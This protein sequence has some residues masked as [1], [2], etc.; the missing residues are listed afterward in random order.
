M[1]C[2]INLL[3]RPEQKIAL[4]DS[5]AMPVDFILKGIAV[6]KHLFYNICIYIIKFI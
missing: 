1:L 3:T 5:T 4:V 2:G 6:Y